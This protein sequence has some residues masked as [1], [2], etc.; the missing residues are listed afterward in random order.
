[1]K[2]NNRKLDFTRLKTISLKKRKSKVSIKDFA[3]TA[4]AGDTFSLFLD[5]LPNILAAKDFKTI[6]AALK[7][8]RKKKKAIILMIG[9]HVVK[10]GLNPILIDLMRKGFITAV[11]INGASAI[12]D[13][14]LAF[15]GKTSEEVEGSIKD[16]SF[17]MSRETAEFFN[18]AI[19]EA[20]ASGQGLGKT[21]G[22]LIIKKRLAFRRFSLLAGS[23]DSGVPL[24][25]HVAIGTDII[26]PHPGCD[27]AALGAGAMQDFRAFMETV[28]RLSGGVVMNI[29]S[30][31]IMPEV[32]LKAVSTARNL[33]FSLE[34]F[35]AVCFDMIKH[36]RPM[37]NVVK[38]PTAS[39]G[40]GYYVIG[41]HEIMLPLLY[42]A[43]VEGEK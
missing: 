21:L 37:Q 11:A 7:N 2:N 35:T 20:A 17:G 10:C 6:I 15:C 43:L 23:I 36:Y 29:G 13:F 12:H 25:V 19:R 30:A 24:T 26:H 39:G 16:G 27:G 1:M 34:N 14:E 40:K 42:R 38:R 8:A 31:V 3:K 22:E 9:A 41:H 4:S 32:F 18:E 5:S 33:G 28:S